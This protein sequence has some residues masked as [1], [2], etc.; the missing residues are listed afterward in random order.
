[1]SMNFLLTA[2]LLLTTSFAK[3]ADKCNPISGMS[4]TKDIKYVISPTIGANIVV[5]I[6]PPTG[7][8]CG[9]KEIGDGME[10]LITKRSGWD[11]LWPIGDWFYASEFIVRGTSNLSDIV[12]FGTFD[13]KARWNGC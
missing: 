4:T 3:K 1:M 7:D 10:Y 9:C 12:A 6:I 8:D 13:L 2:T 11:V 5:D